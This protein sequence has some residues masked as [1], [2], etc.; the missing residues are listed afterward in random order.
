MDLKVFESDLRAQHEA[1]TAKYEA[2]HQAGE[3]S[4][5]A[6]EEAKTELVAFRKQYG[7]VLKALDNVTVEG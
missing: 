3:K 6:Y 5:A 2:A 7:K 1:L 4:W